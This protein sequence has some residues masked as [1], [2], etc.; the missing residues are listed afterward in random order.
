MK[1]TNT[2]L[3]ITYTNCSPKNSFMYLLHLIKNFMY[4]S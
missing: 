3:I 1:L 4:E 2:K